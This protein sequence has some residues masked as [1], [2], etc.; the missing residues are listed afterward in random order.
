[1]AT[2]FHELRERLL[3]AGV[4]PR[5][6]R[7][8][9][10]EL[11]D[12]FADLTAEE[13]RAGGSLSEAQSAALARLGK[14]EDLVLPGG[15]KVVLLF[16]SDWSGVG[17]CRKEKR[18]CPDQPIFPKAKCVS[19]FDS[20]PHSGRS[21]RTARSWHL[22]TQNDD[23]TCPAQDADSEAPQ[24]NRTQ[25]ILSFYAKNAT[26]PE[27]RHHTKYATATADI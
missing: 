8:Y 11:T 18:C 20:E 23:R 12:H 6:V 15:K 1:V 25:Q 17:K 13:Q 27:S 4:A 9:L 19:C 7:R 5:H 10:G 16:L 24:S 26:D 2:R 21:P 3:R 14:T 22:Q